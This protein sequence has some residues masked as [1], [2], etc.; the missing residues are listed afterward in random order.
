MRKRLIIG[1]AFLNCCILVFVYLARV[2]E[3]YAFNGDACQ[4]IAMLA[5][6]KIDTGQPVSEEALRTEIA[7]LIRASVIHGKV[8]ADGGATDLNGHAFQIQHVGNKVAVRTKFSLL[9][10]IR[11]HFEI[12]MH[13]NPAL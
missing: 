7:D 5:A 3:A 6:N 10:P 4:V 13:N 12:K 2:A 11:S 1:L 9:Q 8:T